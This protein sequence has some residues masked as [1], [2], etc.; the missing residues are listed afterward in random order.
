[1]N[2]AIKEKA[3]AA[4]SINIADRMQRQRS[5]DI[6]LTMHS[7]DEPVSKRRILLSQLLV[8]NYQI[9]NSQSHT[10][11]NRLHRTD[12][13]DLCDMA[14]ADLQKSFYTVAQT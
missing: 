10:L 7:K 13:S 12:P 1:M 11:M 3:P 6:T 5:N 8:I 9:Q 14:S 2:P 4:T